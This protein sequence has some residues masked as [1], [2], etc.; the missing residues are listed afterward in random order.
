MF[1]C[2]ASC[3]HWLAGRQAMN[4]AVFECITSVMHLS[5]PEST[6]ER[7]VS[8]PEPHIFWRIVRQAMPA[9]PASKSI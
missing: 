2:S 9:V 8:F 5:T 6:V 1:T 3:A 7:T 4:K